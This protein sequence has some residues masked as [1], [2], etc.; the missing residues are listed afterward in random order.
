MLLTQRATH[1][2]TVTQLHTT[3]LTLQEQRVV[4]GP[5]LQPG[6]QRRVVDREALAR[7]GQ[8]VEVQA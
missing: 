1:S 5:R 3:E 4:S 6:L 2:S 8:G 7:L